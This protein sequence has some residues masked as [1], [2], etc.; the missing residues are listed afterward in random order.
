MEKIVFELIL[1]EEARDFL[2][3]LSKEIR[4][5]IG[6]NIRRVQKGERNVELFKKLE[7]SE[8][9]EFR[10][11]YNKNYYRLFAFWDTDNDSL[12]IATHG[13]IK[14][15]GKTPTTEISKA[16]ELRKKYFDNKN[17]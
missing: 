11:L 13:I 3:S 14:K 16:E 12:V 8:I 15:T 6:I 9:W 5:K 2:K 4:R 7:G 10:T 1:M 17:K